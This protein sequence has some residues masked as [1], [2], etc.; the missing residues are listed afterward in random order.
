MKKWKIIIRFRFVIILTQLPY[1]EEAANSSA[2]RP[3]PSGATVIDR[4]RFPASEGLPK[5]S[6]L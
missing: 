4:N 5:S 6:I 1:L 2:V 3:D